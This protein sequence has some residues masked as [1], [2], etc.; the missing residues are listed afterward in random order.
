MKIA[1]S[2]CCWWHDSLDDLLR[3][4]AEC[5][6]TAVEL[7]TF[8]P[9]LFNPHGNLREMKPADLARKL[10]AH[11]L[12]LAG[13]HLGC[14]RTHDEQLRRSMTDYAKLAID[15][16]VRLGCEVIVEGGPDRGV[17][18]FELHEAAR[19]DLPQDPRD[20]RIGRVQAGGRLHQVLA[21]ARH[22]PQVD[23]AG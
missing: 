8:P 13:L 6:F 15:F 22:Q 4:A 20:D 18:P 12:R 14:I 3:K 7:L 2:S 21:L 11:G 5:G 23:A 16:A 17:G 9:E 10:D 1:A 19:T